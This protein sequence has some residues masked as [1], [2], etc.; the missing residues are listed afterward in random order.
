MVLDIAHCLYHSVCVCV[1][2][3]VS[4]CHRSE[5]G[6][7]CMGLTFGVEASFDLS[8]IVLWGNLGLEKLRSSVPNYWLRTFCRSLQ[9]VV[10]L[11]W[12]GGG[13]LLTVATVFVED[14]AVPSRPVTVHVCP[15][16]VE[17]CGSHRSAETYRQTE[18]CTTTAAKLWLTTG[19]C[20]LW[21]HRKGLWSACINVII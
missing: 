7:R 20:R 12:L 5:N 11:I 1:C 18:N 13:Y 2:V 3:S 14:S 8:C 16:C 6:Y 15:V 21:S 19:A 10:N 17:C 9:H 4:I